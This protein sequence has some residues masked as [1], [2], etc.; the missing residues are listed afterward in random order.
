MSTVVDHNYPLDGEMLIVDKT[1]EP[2]E[3]AIIRIFD[4]T[5]YQA[6]DRDTWEAET[7]TDI[8]GKWIDPVVLEDA[9]TWIVYVEKDGYGPVHIEITT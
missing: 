6:G 8:E 4:L 5:K 9:R 1:N 2:I 3:G 7:L